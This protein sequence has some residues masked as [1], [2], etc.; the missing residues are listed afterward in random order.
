MLDFF[1]FV[2]VVFFMKNDVTSSAVN[3]T[4]TKIE[5]FYLEQASYESYISD[6]DIL[7]QAINVDIFCKI[8]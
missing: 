3:E 1:V 8:L 4:N 7:S 6:Q 2:L 5:A